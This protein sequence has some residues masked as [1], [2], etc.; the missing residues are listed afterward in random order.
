MAIDRVVLEQCLDQLKNNNA[1][2]EYYLPDLVKLAVEG[3]FTTDLVIG[4]VHDTMGVDS[5]L[6]LAKAE[7]IFQSRR[8][9]HFLMSGVTLQ[10]PETVHF[11]HDTDI[12]P[13]VVIEP[14][15]VFGPD[16]RIASGSLIKAFSHLEGARVGMNAVIGPYARLRPGTVLEAGVKIGN[17]V[18]TKKAKIA[19]GAKVNHLS[20]IGDAE[21]GA[22]VNIGAGTITCNYDG[23]NKHKTVIGAGAFIGSN[24][25]LI[26][27]VEIGA[28]A[29]VGSSSALSADV[30]ADALAVTRAPARTIE[31]WARK[32]RDKNSKG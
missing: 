20:Y 28:G 29:Y 19:D 13:D 8:R 15:C 7:N 25:S 21:I 5:R 18:E 3:G 16:V 14:H 23:F 9:Q 11:S 4:D 12:E 22:G 26:A 27:P 17:F 31:G 10:S 1:Q 32:F 2:G 6:G 30:G 24:T